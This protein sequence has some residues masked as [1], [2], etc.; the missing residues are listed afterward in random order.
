MRAVLEEYQKNGGKYSEVTFADCGHS[1]H[2][3]KAADF[4]KEFLEFLESKA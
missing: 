4:R 1:P 3:E 2:I